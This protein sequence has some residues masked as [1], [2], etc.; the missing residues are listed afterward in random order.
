M[1]Q[2]ISSAPIRI[3]SRAAKKKRSHRL[4]LLW[5]VVGGAFG[6]GCG[7]AF[8]PA[9][10]ASAPMEAKAPV[11][12]AALPPREQPAREVKLIIDDAKDDGGKKVDGGAQVRAAAPVSLDLKVANGDTLI[13][14]LT[15]AGAPQED[16]YAILEALRPEFNPRQLNAGQRVSVQLDAS[17]AVEKLTLPLSLTTSIEVARAADGFKVSRQETPVSPKLARA[18]GVISSSLYETAVDAGLPPALLPELISAY[19]Y[20]I[21]F[22]RDIQR[23]H[24]I[25][26]LYERMETKDGIAVGQGEVVFAELDLGDRALKIYRHVSKDGFSDYYNEKGESVRKAL[27]RTPI[28]GARIT[29]GFGMRNHPILGYTKM[30]RGVD[31]GAPSGTPVYAA[32]DGTVEFS[33]RKG[34][35]GNYLRIKHNGQYSSAYAHLSRFAKDV[36]P[37]KRVKQGQIVA[38][39]GSTGRSTGPHLHYEILSAGTQVNPANV[40]FKNG[41]VLKGTELAAFRRDMEKVEAKLASLPRTTRVAMASPPNGGVRSTQ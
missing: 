10:H 22:Q 17:A 8:S 24:E 29:S 12:V 2:R 3:V 30:H 33:G 16:A 6:I 27:L 39:V 31:F 19:S 14:L 1:D 18:G 7:S 21:D 34:A 41:N 20:D 38:Y 35:Y 13:T 5:F 37:G 11:A 36:S 9:F 23:G 40:K 25:D 28:N 4:R 26:V 32:G 15:D